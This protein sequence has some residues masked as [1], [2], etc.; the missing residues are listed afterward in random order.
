[1]SLDRIDNDGDYELSNC[2]WAT[3]STQQYNRNTF[4][5]GNSRYR[6]VSYSYKKW[7][8]LIYKEGMKY[9]FGSYASE[10]E[11]AYIYDQVALQMYGTNAFTNFDVI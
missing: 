9:G 2:R 6:G 11:A 5:P 10:Q 1:M 4:R 3:R 8:V 7:R